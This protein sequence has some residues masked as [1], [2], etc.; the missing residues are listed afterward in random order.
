MDVWMPYGKTQ[1]FCRIPSEVDLE[2]L[3]PRLDG[4]SLDQLLDRVREID[5]PSSV[6][7]VFIAADPFPFCAREI[8][9]ISE[10]VKH[11]LEHRSVEITVCFGCGEADGVE[12]L[13]EVGAAL[14]KLRAQL[15]VNSGSGIEYEGLSGL[16]GP[17]LRRYREADY[18]VVVS[19]LRPSKVFGAFGV[20][21]TLAHAS[22]H[23]EVLAKQRLEL[24][25]EA[26]KEEDPLAVRGTVGG[27]EADFAIQLLRRGDGS[28]YRFWL[29]EPTKCYVEGVRAFSEA[30]AQEVR[31]AY[32]AVLASA[33]GY[34]VDAYLASSVDALAMSA[35]LVE[36]GGKTLLFAAECGSGIGSE[37]FALALQKCPTYR[38]L[39]EWAARKP[40]ISVSQA[41]LAR[42]VSERV[43]GVM[44]TAAPKTYVEDMLG[45]LH[46]DTL[47]EGAEVINLAR[48]KRVCVLRNASLVRRWRAAR[49]RAKA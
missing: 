44:V 24:V 32:D 3:E 42:A 41:L 11:L 18:R 43:S 27:L 34:P 26:L 30:F 49:S 47:R 19:W 23:P 28:L 7:R 5:L 38:E 13:D 31:S 4:V 37:A 12:A 17:I 33:G 39:R 10:L 29:G 22:L 9:L 21:Q 48:K 20:P 2:V 14:R 35:D 15:V 40:L 45:F 1:V 46:A 16:S 36:E 6:Q 25:E 8:D